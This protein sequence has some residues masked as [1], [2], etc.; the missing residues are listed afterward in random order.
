MGIKR[1]LIPLPG[2]VAH[3]NEIEMGL[4]AATAMGAQVEAM[5]ITEPAPSMRSSDV[6]FRAA[7]A[8]QINQYAEERERIA[9]D[10][11]ERF[12]H[13]CANHGIPM[14]RMH[15]L[16]DVL[17]AASWR[18]SEGSYDAVAVARA[19]GF[20]LIVAASAAVMEALKAIAEASLLQAR[21][22]VL[23]TPPQMPGDLAGNAMIAWD[24][25]PECWHAVSAAIPFLRLART[26]QVVSVDRYAARRQASQADAV[27]YLRCH[28]ITATAKVV[29]PHLRSVGDTLLAVAE[30]VGPGLLVMGAYSHSRLREMLLGVVTRHILKNAVSRPVLLAH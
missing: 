8:V 23:L 6:R 11:R 14:I 3:Q 13:A 28:G 21:R 30:E 15:E 25:S 22:P 4:M 5:F 19:A 2:S 10:A 17:P 18:E 24:E 1:I 7:A 9:A 16:P 27:A 29:A 12:T 26:V 20:D